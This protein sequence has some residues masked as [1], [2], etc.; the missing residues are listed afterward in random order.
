M[1]S[2]IYDGTVLDEPACRL[3]VLDRVKGRVAIA[4][5]DIYVA[6]WMKPNQTNE[7][8]REGCKHTAG[9]KIVKNVQLA[10]GGG[11]MP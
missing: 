1:I 2:T 9:Y 7:E 4:V 6:A 5:L 10:I 8:W 3:D 11:G